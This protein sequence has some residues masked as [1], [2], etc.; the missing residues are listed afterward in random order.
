MQGESFFTCIKQSIIIFFSDVMNINILKPMSSFRASFSLSS[1]HQDSF[2][3]GRTLYFSLKN[4]RNIITIQKSLE[5]YLDS[6][7]SHGQYPP[8]I[9]DGSISKLRICLGK[10]GKNIS[11][12]S[13]RECSIDCLSH[14]QNF[15]IITHI[16]GKL[17]FKQ[18]NNYLQH[19]QVL[20]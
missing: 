19:S 6:K 1:C 12:F 3:L 15:V 5:S 7:N 13:Q 17:F 11:C 4:M 8:V 2:R 18:V 20:Q 9:C 16:K 14:F 10:N